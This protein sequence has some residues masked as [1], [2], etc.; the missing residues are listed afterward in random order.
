MN[1][2]VLNVLIADDEVFIREGLK[3]IIDWHAL[4]F[5]I[6]GEAQDGMDALEKMASFHPS[7]VLLDIQM[8]LL[9]GIELIQKARENGFTGEFIILSGFSDFQ[10][11]QA[12]IRYGVSCYLTKPIDETLLT[13]AVLSAKEKI[14]S[15]LRTK[16]SYYRYM[17]KARDTVLRDLLRN[18]QPDINIHYEEFGFT[19]PVY[20][21]ILYENLEPLSP[22][23]H[24][25][26]IF[27]AVCGPNDSYEQLT[28]DNRHLLLLKG[29]SSL[30]RFQTFLSR[31][32]GRLQKGSPLDSAFLA[33]GRPVYSLKEFHPSYAECCL[34][35]ERRFF[36]QPSRH[37]LSPE[38][39]PDC[40]RKDTFADSPH[41]GLY[42]QELSDYVKSANRKMIVETLG[43][44]ESR[45]LSCSD[46]TA[47]LKHFL[48]D[49]LLQVRNSVL[50]SYSQVKE[51]LCSNAAL[52]ERV[53]QCRTLYEIMTYYMEQ[54]EIMINAVGG[55]SDT[56]SVF[57][58][59][60]DYINHNYGEA[61]K[62]EAL[63]PLFGYNSS[64]LGKLF[65]QRMG[66][67]FNSY[68][69]EIR[70]RNAA[71]MLSET[72]MSA[73]A[74]AALSGY[75]SVDYFYQKFK[76]EF[77]CS[78]AEYRK[79]QGQDRGLPPVL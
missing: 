27:A 15:G 42:A 71:R 11:A 5:D 57:E 53:E 76:R 45:L 79:K 17:M 47:A 55:N 54:F 66:K 43:E 72:N 36:C 62:L 10:Y 37:I 24:F 20:Q 40:L 69:N 56:D 65:T 50:Q 29:Q 49:I 30:T 18:P 75:R 9:S 74:V 1:E 70:V 63:A 61:L 52:I 33:C 16:D 59:I 8:P 12:A 7:L 2:P 23:F 39:L 64:Y 35:M 51:F 4:G 44:L 67:N 14:L 31:C 77:G 28:L 68:L 78:P 46:S 73:S 41:A 58:N 26:E 25:G 48:A 6:C 19:F 34:L 22:R 3:Y 38:D 13:Q 21:L 60:L 32:Q